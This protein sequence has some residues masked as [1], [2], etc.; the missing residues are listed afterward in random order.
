[1]RTRWRS[2]TKLCSLEQ[3]KSVHVEMPQLGSI[4]MDR[5]SRQ[6]LLGTLGYLIAIG[7]IVATLGSAFAGT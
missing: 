2:A 7:G 6:L 1:L 5:E 4:D 3:G